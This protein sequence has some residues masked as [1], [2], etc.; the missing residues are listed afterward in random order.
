MALD[1][2]QC[3]VAAGFGSRGT[4]GRGDRYKVTVQV[5]HV[6]T[7]ISVAWNSELYAKRDCPSWG[8]F[9][10]PLGLTVAITLYVLFLQS[11]VPNTGKL[12]QSTL[13]AR[14]RPP[15]RDAFLQEKLDPFLNGCLGSR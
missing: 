11:T 13:N 12:T 2:T 14:N 8:Y 4:F 5:L 9:L 15:K 7:V 6:I 10:N 1:K 3:D